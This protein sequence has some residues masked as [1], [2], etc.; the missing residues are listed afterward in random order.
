MEV[1]P[2][3]APMTAM[4]AA[5]FVP[6]NM[7]ATQKVRKM[8][9]WAAAPKISSFGLVS[10]GPKSIMAPIPINR[11]SGNS[12]LAIPALNRVESAPSCTPP[13]TAWSMAPESGILT[14]M[15]P[16]PSGSS[17]VGSISL[18]IAR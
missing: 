14:R 10:S 17:S 7:E 5:S 6:K 9:N 12:S 18:A 2:S 11:I 13:F 4:E 3:A 8:P 1:G 16:K 15:V